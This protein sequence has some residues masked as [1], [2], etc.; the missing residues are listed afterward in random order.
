MNIPPDPIESGE[1]VELWRVGCQF[2]VLRRPR[3]RD[4]DFE[5]SVFEE[6]LTASPLEIAH[7]V[8]TDETAAADMAIAAMHDAEAIW[9][10]HREQH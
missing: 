2:C 8:L 7:A 5:I 9:R 3:R 4:P 6:R 10:W 1:R